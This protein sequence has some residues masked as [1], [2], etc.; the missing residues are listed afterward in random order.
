MKISNETK[1]GA[2][3]CI[4]IVLLILGFN[5]LKGK[6]F[7][8]KNEHFYAVFDNIQGLANSNPITING[9]QV[10]TVTA[11][12]GGRDM[13]RIVVTMTL[14]QT[15]DIPDNSVV[16]IVPSILG[17]TS[18]DIKLGNNSALYKNGDTILT[19]ATMGTIDEAFQKI[20]PVLIEVKKAVGS[21]DSVLRNVNG[22]L[23][24]NAKEAIKGTML[25]LNKTTANLA[26]SSASLQNMLDPQTGAVGKT[27]NNLSSVT[28]TLAKNNDQ[29]EQTLTNVNKTTANLANLDLQKTLTT[30]NGTI[31]QLKTQLSSESGTAGK[32][33][34]NASL[35]NNLNATANKINLL[36]DDIRVHPKRYVS[37][38]VFGKKDKSE[39]LAVPLPDTVN[40]PYTH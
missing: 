7:T 39:P 25:N 19:K 11:T 38:S 14:N 37:I 13:R 29:I 33:L 24:D 10:G 16:T 3:T 22:L 1:I 36:L 26:I 12:D 21:L 31:D 30:L 15:L 40:A 23:D 20:D 6:S 27:M 32:F 5:F 9:K 8:G 2:L 28:G 18:M 34:N 17:T 4:S 35:Y